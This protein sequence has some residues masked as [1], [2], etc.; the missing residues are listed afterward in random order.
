[1][2]KAL[3][4]TVFISAVAAGLALA[5][6]ATVAASTGAPR[7]AYPT[8]PGRLYSVAAISADDVWAVGLD[9]CCSLAVHWDGSTWSEYD[10]SS[11]GYYYGVGGSSADEVWAVGGT[12]W[13]SPTYTLA[14][15]WDGKSW[16]QVTTPSPPGGG[17][18]V[19]VAATSPA[20]AWAV[21]LAGP[22]SGVPSPTTPLIEH[23]N[24]KTW[25]I[26]R[27][28]IPADGGQLD[29]VAATSPANAW[30]V[31]YTGDAS[32]GTG[33]QTLIEHWNGKTWTRVASPNVSNASASSLTGVT[34]I[35]ADNAWAVGSANV[36]NSRETL[37]LYWNGRDWTQVPSATPGGDAQLIGVAASWTHNIWAVGI[38]NPNLCGNGGP[39]CQTLIEHWN[40]KRWKVI[41]SP[42]P[43]SGYLNLLWDIS[44]VSRT[45]IW[46]VG[47]T[48]YGS[49]L[50]E[51][52]N[53]T[54]WS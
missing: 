28:Q 6:P 3:G 11:N 41:S 34:V 50:I 46:A 1:M 19:G 23:W 10:G 16:R 15:H 45:D 26:Q 33:Q 39:Q 49:T 37:I 47:T 17:F 42:N 24:G 25:T 36:G 53:G 30:A 38:T 32:E 2:K 4:W 5:V 20:N 22:G 40:S 48:D 13:F 29:R 18:L 27:I 31:G 14:E 52:W 43:P 21:G 9:G 51:H 44:A 8:V 35:S 54:S 12:N 7:P